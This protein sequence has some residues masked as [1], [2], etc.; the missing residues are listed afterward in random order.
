MGSNHQSILTVHTRIGVEGIA[1]N[2]NS[3][4][5]A[6]KPRIAGGEAR[7]PLCRNW[8]MMVRSAEQNT[9]DIIAVPLWKN[10]IDAES[11]GA[12]ICLAT[13]LRFPHPVLEAE[14]YSDDGKSSLGGGVNSASCKEGKQE[15]GVL[16][17]GSENTDEIWIIDYSDLH[18]RKSNIDEAMNG[19]AL[20]DSAAIVDVVPLPTDTVDNDAID[21]ITA[22]GKSFCGR[23]HR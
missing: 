4:E 15:L 11:R 10:D 21:V 2:S 9:V 16:L 8:V 13:R 1:R 14:F 6:F 23:T 7:S 17:S 5:G 22:R 18:F 19:M 20:D 3:L 12:G